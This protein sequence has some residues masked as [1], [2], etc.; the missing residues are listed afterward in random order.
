[1]P[2]LFSFVKIANGRPSEFNRNGVGSRN[3][4]SSNP[5]DG[6]TVPAG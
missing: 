3:T 5:L 2:A 4:A 1:L 6:F